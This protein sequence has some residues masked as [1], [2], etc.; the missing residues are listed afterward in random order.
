MLANIKAD[1]LRASRHSTD[2][3]LNQA[4]VEKFISDLGRWYQVLPE[5][6]RFRA[7][8][9]GHPNPDVQGVVFYL[10]L[11]QLSAQTLL[12]RRLLRLDLDFPRRIS[13]DAGFLQTAKPV[14]NDGPGHARVVV[15]ILA[16][17]KSMN[18]IFNG[19]KWLCL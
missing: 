18:N 11:L 10:H 17:L 13:A 5:H 8:G 14:R 1:I 19:T 7:D 3:G 12:Y 6:L 9:D 2:D 4:T 15:G 16:P